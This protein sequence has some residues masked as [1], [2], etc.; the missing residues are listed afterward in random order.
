MRRRGRAGRSMPSALGTPTQAGLG[1][2]LTKSG[3]MT[4]VRTPR[5]V[6]CNAL[7]RAAGFLDCTCC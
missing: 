7:G 3:D 6:G 1:A 2:L 4:H 5:V